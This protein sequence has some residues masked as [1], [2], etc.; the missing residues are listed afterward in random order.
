MKKTCIIIA[1]PTAVGK[2]EVALNLARSFN[3]RIISADSR[4]CFTELSIGV[5]KPAASELAEVFHYFINTHSIHENISAASFEKYALAS[6]DEIF[7]DNDITIMVGGTGLY[8]NA[9]CHG[10]DPIPNIEKN[11]REEIM[12]A[13]ENQGIQWLQ[14]KIMKE[15]PAFHASGEIHNP[16]RMMRALEV[17]RSTGKSIQA[18]RNTQKKERP[19]D[20]IKIGLE[21]PRNDLYQRINKRVDIMIQSGLENEAR[22]LLPFRN[23]NAL[24]TVGYREL[25]SYFDAE[26]TRPQAINLI[27]QHTR[28]YAKRQMT[29]FKK[30]NEIVWLPPDSSLVF[31]YVSQKIKT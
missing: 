6:A 21:L 26:M 9:F 28:N 5:A 8:I 20:I 11:I 31:R 18:F 15:D 14:E 1:G 25:F 4:Q 30:D 29:W 3:T 22:S 12:A 13:Y 27:K 2:T 19:F 7:L 17:I 16:Q 24:Q 10:L 23:L